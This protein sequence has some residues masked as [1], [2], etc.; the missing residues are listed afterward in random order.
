M[1]IRSKKAFLSSPSTLQTQRS[2]QDE[3][4]SQPSWSFRL[5]KSSLNHV[6]SAKRLDKGTQKSTCLVWNKE[7]MDKL[8]KKLQLNGDKESQMGRKAEMRRKK[9]IE[10]Q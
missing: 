8:S 4:K 3:E 6:Q 2:A 7:A 1:F 10:A 5:Q 9:R